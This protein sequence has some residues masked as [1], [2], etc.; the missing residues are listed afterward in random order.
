MNTRQKTDCLHVTL[1]MTNRISGCFILLPY[2]P[3]PNLECAGGEVHDGLAVQLQWLLWV[4]F[5]TAR[6]LVIDGAKIVQAERKSKLAC[7]FSEAPP[8]FKLRK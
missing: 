4:V 1:G 3:P 6:S 2:H 7:I 8:I 5:H